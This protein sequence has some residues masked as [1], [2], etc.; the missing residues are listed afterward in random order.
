MRALPGL[1]QR[2]PWNPEPWAAEGTIK[3][4]YDVIRIL[5]RRSPLNETRISKVWQHLRARW[6]MNHSLPVACLRT[7]KFLGGLAVEGGPGPLYRIVPPIPTGSEFPDWFSVINQNTWRREK[8]RK[9]YS[10]RYSVDLSEDDSG[11]LAKS[12]LL[13]TLASDDVPAVSSVLRKTWLETI[14][15]KRHMAVLVKTEPEDQT[16]PIILN[17]FP[18]SDPGLLMTTLKERSPLFGALPDLATVVADFHSLRPKI[19]L[20]AFLRQHFPKGNTLL[21]QFHKSW[22]LGERIDY[23]IGKIPVQSERIHPMLTEVWQRM[24]AIQMPPNRYLRRLSFVQIAAAEERS[25]WN[26]TL[27]A[28]LYGW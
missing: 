6:C 18:I 16:P 1:M 13:N 26:S 10:E 3:A 21:Q 4:V 14:K 9:Y 19:S 22:Y 24:I 5:R 28:T 15:T 27:S 12:Q 23:L 25:V 11:R 7:P 17:A 8:L 20:S 2:K